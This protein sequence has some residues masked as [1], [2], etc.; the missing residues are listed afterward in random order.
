MKHIFFFLGI[1]LLLFSSCGE[2]GSPVSEN[3]ILEGGEESSSHQKSKLLPVI[4]DAREYVEG[5]QE[6]SVLLELRE[7]KKD[8]KISEIELWL[9]NPE[10]KSI[11]SVR[12]LVSFPSDILSGKRIYFPKN[13]PF[14]LIAPGE[15]SFDQKN[16]LAKI[17]VSISEEKS[18]EDTE[19][20]IATFVF[21]RKKFFSAASIDI[22]GFGDGEETL[23]LAQDGDNPPYDILKSPNIPTLSLFPSL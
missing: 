8:Q 7:K 13:T 1:F 10:R 12:T 23:V 16:G 6:R 20:R 11:I 18:F 15:S 3:S 9:K 5:T 22:Y 21:E 17:G 2:K 19:I 4:K 14:S